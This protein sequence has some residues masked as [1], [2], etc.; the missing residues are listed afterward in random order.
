MADNWQLKAVLSANAESMLKTLN[1]VNKAT[2]T[3]RKYLS[4]VGTGSVNLAQNLALPVAALGSL[5]AGFS[6]YGIKQAVTNFAALGDEVA[7][8]SQ[9]IGVSIPEY[10]RLK[11]VAGQSG[12]SVEELGSSVGRLN[13]GVAQAASGG[14]QKLA[15]LF[16]KAG[17]SMRD[18]N[19]ELRSGA[20]LLP[21][22]ADLFERNKNAAVQANMGNAIFGKSWQS[23]A[24]LLQSGSAGINELT[25]RYKML[26]IEVDAGAIKAGE[27]FGDQMEDL[28]HVVRS[29]GNMIT[30]KLLPVLAPLLEKT[31]NWAIANRELITS[32]VSEF[33]EKIAD[34][35]SKVDWTNVIEGV[36]SFFKGL[37]NLIDMLGGAQN[38]LIALVVVMNAGTIVAVGQLITSLVLAGASLGALLW[39]ITAIAAAGYLIYKNWDTLGPTI[40]R[41]VDPLIAAV[42][43][44]VSSL[45]DMFSGLFSAVGNL[46]TLLGPVVLPILKAIGYI[47]GGSIYIALKLVIGTVTTLIEGL[48]FVFDLVGNVANRIAK[49]LGFAAELGASVGGY[50][51][52]DSTAQAAPGG[53][54]NR[55]LLNASEGRVS[56]QV[57]VNFNNMPPGTR[58]EQVASGGNMPLNLDAGYRSDAMG[59]AF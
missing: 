21:E 31:I 45:G 30:S 57:N 44:F 47:I 25:E 39:P 46:A 38:A 20:D 26:G 40:M 8:S 24:P 34:K 6:L 15:S 48:T 33:I 3:T 42:K 5:A 7:K 59:M 19:G 41:I 58:V 4:D 32:K 27:A 53:A 10:Q 14:N 16:A 51:G 52:A 56:G 2:K 54:S 17:I 12:V 9:R 18:A 29:Y 35:L 28:N 1:A 13:K 43:G 37:G 49:V 55:S 36:G 22:I 23:L 11:Y 50:F